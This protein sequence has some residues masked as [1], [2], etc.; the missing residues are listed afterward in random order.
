MRY[1]NLSECPP[2]LRKLLT[3]QRVALPKKRSKFGN[4]PV[5]VDGIR[6]PSKAQARRDQQLK[7]AVAH[8]AIYGYVAEVS[9]RLPGGNR[10]RLDSLVNEPVNYKC[11]QCGAHNTVATLVL[12]D[13]KGHVAKEWEVKRKALE[14]ALR[15][16]VRIVSGR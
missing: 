12:E 16:K 2:G 6:F 13:V 4:V 1:K 5:T 10:I 7:L 9:I 8:G 14:G 15:V 11:T 3:E